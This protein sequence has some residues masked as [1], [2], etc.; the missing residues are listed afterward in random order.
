M[1]LGYIRQ[2]IKETQFNGEIVFT[3]LDA[4]ESLL[5][6]NGCGFEFEN[7]NPVIKVNFN[8]NIPYS[9]YY[10]E[11]KSF[12]DMKKFYIEYKYQSR[13]KQ[14]NENLIDILEEDI[15]EK[16]EIFFIKKREIS[17]TVKFYFS[18]DERINKMAKET[19]IKGLENI[20]NIDE[21]S[22]E[23]LLDENYYKE[24]ILNRSYRTTLFIDKGYYILDK[25]NEKTEFAFLKVSLSIAKGYL[26]A[27]TEILKDPSIYINKKSEYDIY[28]LEDKDEVDEIEYDFEKDYKKNIELLKVN[29]ENITKIIKERE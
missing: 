20:I 1:N 24:T 5:L 18:E 14:E 13:I 23:Q 22:N 3:P 16:R 12:E 11:E 19:V 26:L 15:K 27:L 28:E 10:K 9:N 29:I 17:E 6:G 7:G 25:V 4:L 8:R 2:F 21:L